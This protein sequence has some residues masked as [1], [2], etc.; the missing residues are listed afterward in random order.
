MSSVVNHKNV[1]RIENKISDCLNRAERYFKIGLQRPSFNFKQRGRTAGTAYLQRNEMRFN[2]YM[3]QQDPDK[4]I[5]HVVPHELAHIVV[6]QVFGSKVRPHGKEW[7]A[8]MEHLFDVEASRTHDFDVPKPRNLFLYQ[9][10]CQVHE[11]TA[12]RHGRAVKG[13]Q[14]VC[15]YCRKNLNFLKK[16]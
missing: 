5:D 16:K 12:H 1:E 14:Y 2:T 7:I 3:L 8:V 9:C 13:T 15:R 11:F 10:A 6:Y 4:F